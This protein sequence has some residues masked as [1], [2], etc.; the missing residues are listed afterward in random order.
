MSLPARKACWNPV[1]VNPSHWKPADIY[2][3]SLKW[4]EIKMHVNSELMVEIETKGVY[5]VENPLPR[6]VLG[7]L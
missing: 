1:G 7:Q 6:R 2:P 3:G 5:G 4:V